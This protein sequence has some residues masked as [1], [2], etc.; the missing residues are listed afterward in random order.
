MC[1]GMIGYGWKGPF[2]IWIAETTEER[3]KAMEEIHSMNQSMVD[4]AERY[5]ALQSSCH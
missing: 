3:E 4:E 2:H 5:V 1:W